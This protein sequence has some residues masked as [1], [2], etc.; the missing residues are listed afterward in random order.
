MSSFNPALREAWIRRLAGSGR[1]PSLRGPSSGPLPLITLPINK[2]FSSDTTGVAPDH[3]TSWDVSAT[4]DNNIPIVAA[5]TCNNFSATKKLATQMDATHTSSCNFDLAGGTE[6]YLPTTGLKVSV[7]CEGN[8]N[9][10][11][12]HLYLTKEPGEASY[13][14]GSWNEGDLEFLWD[15]DADRYRL[16]VRNSSGGWDAV[17]PNT[18]IGTNLNS[19]GDKQIGATATPGSGDGSVFFSCSNM[20]YTGVYD[21]SL[22]SLTWSYGSQLRYLRWYRPQL[23]YYGQEDP[24]M[25]WVGGASDSI[26][27]RT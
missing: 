10:N 9:S 5:G 8:G 24:F 21:Q 2:Q 26:P 13:T 1:F 25:I 14:D 17:M 16:Q 18:S 19:G 27:W 15:Y 6:A 20:F 3:F 4:L 12:L 11:T 23:G 7:I 22:S